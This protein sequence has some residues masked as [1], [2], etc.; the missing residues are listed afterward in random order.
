MAK[1]PKRDQHVKQ[2]LASA[3]LAGHQPSAKL[4]ELTDQYRKGMISAGEMV[5]RMRKHYRLALA[6]VLDDHCNG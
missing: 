1:D 5:E 4:L 6:K 3:E 2:A